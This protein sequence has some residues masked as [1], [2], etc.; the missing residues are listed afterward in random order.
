MESL[1]FPTRF[2]GEIYLFVNEIG[3]VL[4]GTDASTVLPVENDYNALCQ[5]SANQDFK[6]VELYNE[7]VQSKVTCTDESDNRPTYSSYLLA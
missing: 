5:H 2:V 1:D 6:A 4:I 3:V 7:S